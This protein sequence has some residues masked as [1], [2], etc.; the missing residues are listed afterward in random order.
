MPEEIKD[1]FKDLSKRGY[2]VVDHG[3]IG[4][5]RGCRGI[6]QGKKAKTRQK[7][8]DMFL[9]NSLIL[10]DVVHGIDMHLI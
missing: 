6:K 5:G 1:L 7:S 3:S 2:T 8:I 9:R 10:H 4:C